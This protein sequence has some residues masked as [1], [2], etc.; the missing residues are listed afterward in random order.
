MPT[1][2][3]SLT[4]FFPFFNDAQTVDPLIEQAYYYGG[5]LTP[6]LEVIAIHGGASKDDTLERIL[7]AKRKRP[8]LVVL[9]H[10]D[11]R[12]GYGVIRHGFKAATKEWVF[13]TDGDGQYHLNDLQLLAEEANKSPFDVVNGYK[14]SRSDPWYRILLGKG[15]QLFSRLLFQ[16]P[17]RDVDCDFRLIRKSYLKDITFLSKNS[18]ILP[19]LLLKLSQSGAR[20]SEV[21][22]SHYPRLYG[23]S[24]YTPLKLLYEKLIGDL[25]LKFQ[26][27]NRPLS[28]SLIF[29]RMRQVEEKLWW[30]VTLRESLLTQ[31]EKQPSKSL[32]CDVGCGTGC[33]IEFL[34]KR[35]KTI[36][37]LDKSPLAL[38]H[39]RERGLTHLYQGS[40]TNLPFPN[41]T[42]DCL[43]V[44]DVF[45]M[46]T[47][48]EKEQAVQE[49]NRVLKPNGTLILN[50]PTY[51][52]LYSQHDLACQSKQRFYKQEL[53]ALL[54]DH[55]FSLNYSTHRVC[56]L[57]P[58]IA[59]IKLLKKFTLRTKPT[60]D[61][62]VPLA[63]LNWL[64]TKIQRL[65]NRWIQ[66]G[67]KLPFGSSIFLVARKK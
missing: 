40:I 32:I 67:I 21:P 36:W 4:I 34:R 24:N 48:E 17:I 29:Q 42:F 57:F 27:Q 6:N 64:L 53:Q 56:L 14:I 60:L 20:F 38:N 10:T 58:F 61:L 46:I 9:D 39:C 5:Q 45:C 30:Y 55:A 22:V 33:N 2:L 23:Q 44:A 59:A 11:N 62:R 63:P 49:L 35:N 50:E 31:L 52:W 1:D 66:K 25:K 7:K 18:S 43:I 15:Y 28:E 26:I 16:L 3:P 54:A 13:Y 47:P 51:P 65:E 41:D 8:D 37:G 19:E 12:D